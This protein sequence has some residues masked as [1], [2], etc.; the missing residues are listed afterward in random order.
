M[1][2]NLNEMLK[3]YSASEE[4]WRLQNRVLPIDEQMAEKFAH[5]IWFQALLRQRGYTDSLKIEEFINPD[6]TG[7]PDPFLFPDMTKAVERLVTALLRQ[8]R[9][10]VYGDY[11]ADGVTSLAVI[12]KALTRLGFV[13][14]LTYIPDRF[15]EGYGMNPEA[16]QL[17][18]DEEVDLVLTVDCGVT[19]VTE[20]LMLQY[21]SIDLIITDHHQ[22]SEVLPEALAIINP[23]CRKGS[24][25]FA[26]LAGVGVAYE[27]IRALAIRLQ[28]EEILQDL[29]S[30]V[31]LGTIGDSVS[32]AGVNRILIQL[33][34]RELSRSRLAGLN[35]L[36]K[37]SKVSGELNSHKIQFNIVP[38]LNAAGRMQHA[39][40]ALDL[41]LAENPD[42]AEMLAIEVDKQNEL[43][44]KVEQ[45]V[46]QEALDQYEN[47][48]EERKK[49]G[50]A[51]FYA[52][53]W[54]S[55]V[56]GI[57]AARLMERLQRPVLI[58]TADLEGIR[59]SG[60]AP[61]GYNL[62]AMFSK[63]S[64]LLTRFGGHQLAAGFS[65]QED[66][67]EEFFLCLGEIVKGY[68]GRNV[69]WQA[70]L[71]APHS[72]WQ[73]IYKELHKLEP[74]GQGNDDPLWLIRGAEVQSARLISE[75]QHLTARL[76]IGEHQVEIVAWRQGA[77]IDNFIG[78]VDLLARPVKSVFRGH[79]TIRL[80]VQTWRATELDY[81]DQVTKLRKLP[82]NVCLKY[83][84]NMSY[85]ALLETAC[86]FPE[87]AL[88]VP[89]YTQVFPYFPLTHCFGDQV[90]SEQTFALDSLCVKTKDI[91]PFFNELRQP[92]E[93]KLIKWLLPDINDLRHYYRWLRNM[94]NNDIQELLLTDHP[95]GLC[96]KE[97][98][99]SLGNVL[100]I[101]IEAGF[102]ACL[103]HDYT[104]L[105]VQ[106]KT[107]IRELASFQTLVEL[108]ASLM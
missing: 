98:I 18:I 40:L 28:R 9:I 93:K 61:K 50:I 80:E 12:V 71:E 55:G 86:L 57:V 17:L 67:L 82:E 70:D 54:H 95:G 96:G 29:A 73:L 13:T 10:A 24:Y 81:W 78:M 11:D 72:D 16:V 63:A 66:K 4:T 33:G 84:L 37:Q 15:D 26:E 7:L 14:P 23:Q 69:E 21:A 34:L 104:W 2:I 106:P 44:K 32:V 62:H 107:N 25:P 42:E 60:R 94:L 100:P 56:I 39:D 58:G 49:L 45:E 46:T 101:F 85:Y 3:D 36:L 77:Q 38:K 92:Y 76:K 91:I 89:S 102:I 6:L 90:F 27:L 83:G 20:A 79:E 1:R 35:A 51:L 47:W 97:A 108:R 43:R 59:G 19:S 75:G 103:D 31:A 87:Q 105:E 74:F 65:C 64:H 5:P 99:Y 48:P 68:Q 88:V 52:P 8:E 30:F 41:L 22:P 53:H